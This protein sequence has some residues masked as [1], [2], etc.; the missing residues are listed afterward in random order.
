MQSCLTPHNGRSLRPLQEAVNGLQGA[1]PET[2]TKKNSDLDADEFKMKAIAT[3]FGEIMS[4]LGLDLKDDSL[5]DTPRRV[6]KMFVQEIFSG[7]NRNTKPSISLFANKYGYNE[8]LLQKNISL[9][10]TCEHHFLPFIGKVHVGY[11]PT[12]HI[13]GLS[14]INRVVQYFAR[15]PQLQERLTVQINQELQQIL[16]TEDVGVM[17]Q[18]HHLCVASRG[19]EDGNSSTTTTCLS[20]RFN[21]AAT[22]DKFLRSVSH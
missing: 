18:A 20:G 9:Y 11:I 16:K 17:I 14:K 19:I 5:Q 15:R 10:S 13:I 6:A 21:E 12:S 22:H 8:M 1:A 7:L 4:L 2:Q 3:H